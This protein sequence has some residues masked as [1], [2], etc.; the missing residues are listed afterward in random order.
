MSKVNSFNYCITSYLLYIY[1]YP[2]GNLEFRQNRIKIII[3]SE[4]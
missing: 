2:W 1:I 4:V 3:I